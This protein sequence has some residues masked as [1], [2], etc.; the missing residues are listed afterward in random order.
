SGAGSA[1][2]PA[3]ASG[4]QAAQ[5]S[6]ATAPTSYADPAPQP[7]PAPVPPSAVGGRPP[8]LL[9]GFAALT[10][11]GVAG[12]FMMRGRGEA[13]APTPA[14]PATATDPDP[15]PPTGPPVVAGPAAGDDQP[16]PDP[17]PTTGA[18]T[19]PDPVAAPPG[20]DPPA[21]G[22]NPAVATGGDK[23]STAPEAA[24]EPE[25]NGKPTGAGRPGRRPQ[26][27]KGEAGNARALALYTEA[28][29]H[30]YAGRE[31]RALLLFR[32]ALRAGDLP[33]NKRSE[34]DTQIINLSRKFGEIEILTDIAGAQVSVD[35]VTHGRTPLREPILVRPGT[36]RVS[37][38]IP[39]QAPQTRN[40]QVSAGQKAPITLKH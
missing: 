25:T 18:G 38:Q 5:G 13:P 15:A 1:A 21:A 33:P 20:T 31:D 17:D 16:A 29:K 23:P 2:P 37:L 9:L 24:P 36:H 4:P 22:D 28:F 8:W 30:R 32:A 19:T 11:V 40:V 14:G 34:V 3:R 27:S 6:I 39:G 10:V 35:G 26:P 12:F 7:G